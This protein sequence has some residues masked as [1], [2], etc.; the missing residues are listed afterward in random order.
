VGKSGGHPSG[1]SGV[2]EPARTYLRPPSVV[3]S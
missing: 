2:S 3:P 1:E